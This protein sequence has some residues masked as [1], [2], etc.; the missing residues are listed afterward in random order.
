MQ[1]STIF[2]VATRATPVVAAA[3]CLKPRS[4]LT[5]TQAR[6]VDALKQSSPEFILMRSLGMRFRGIFR[7][8]DPGKLNSWI[9]DAVN[10]GLVA[11]ERFARVL[12]RDLDA[13]YNAIELPWSNGQAEGQINRR[14]QSSVQCMAELAR[15]CSVHA[16]WVR[17]NAANDLGFWLVPFPSE[18]NYRPRHTGPTRQGSGRYCIRFLGAQNVNISQQ[19]RT[20]SQL[21]RSTAVRAR[22]SVPK[23]MDRSSG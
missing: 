20:A 9:D 15:S 19:S 13:V 17:A 8:R 6:R 11:I 2:A 18:N 16:C 10:S 21:R 12:H 1:N 14:R 5:I 7:S 22:A 3:L 23:A 4:M